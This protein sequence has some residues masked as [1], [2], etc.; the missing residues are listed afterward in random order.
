M[1]PLLLLLFFP[2]LM[3]AQK[4][5]LLQDELGHYF[6]EEVMENTDASSTQLYETVINWISVNYDLNDIHFEDLEK[7]EI[8][9][10]G[11]INTPCEDDFD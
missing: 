10:K 6:Y 2:V 5:K 9:F 1:R 4:V 8:I 7:G 11:R 3:H